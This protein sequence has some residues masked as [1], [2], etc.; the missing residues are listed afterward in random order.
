MLTGLPAWAPVRAAAV[1]ADR[2]AL[3]ETSRWVRFPLDSGLTRS[4][5]ERIAEPPGGRVWISAR[6]TLAWFDGFFWR[7]AETPPGEIGKVQAFASL[8]SRVVVVTD[9]GVFVESEAGPSLH[10]VRPESPSPARFTS[11]ARLSPSSVAVVGVEGSLWRLRGD[12]LEP[13]RPGELEG[14]L[15]LRAHE[16]STG[17]AWLETERGLYR[18]SGERWVPRLPAATRVSVPAICEDA[19]GNGLLSIDDPFTLRGVWRWSAGGPIERVEGL[20]RRLVTAVECASDNAIVAYGI[21]HAYRRL[22]GRWTRVDQEAPQLANV[23]ALRER[24]TGDL[25]VATDTGLHLFRRSARRWRVWQANGDPETSV[26]N[27][28]LHARDGTIWLG[29]GRGAMRFLPSGE[30]GLLAASDGLP[31]LAVTALGQDRRGRVW[32]AS[33]SF[34]GAYLFTGTRWQKVPTGTALDGRY[35]HKIRQDRA[36]RLWFLTLS[37]VP[38][39]PSPTGEPP[40]LFV[41]DSDRVEFWPESGA[42]PGSRVYAFAEGPDGSLWFGTSGGLS[43]WHEGG[44]RHWTTEEGLPD[45]RVFALAADRA[46]RVWLADGYT[47]VSRI[48][49]DRVHRFTT[50]DGLAS[51]AVWD[52]AVGEDGTVWAATRGGL[53]WYRDDVWMS[54]DAESGMP[55]TRLWPVLPLG[56]HVWLGSTGGLVA[57]DLRDLA[58]PTP[59]VEVTDALVWHGRALLRWRAAAWWSEIPPDRVKTRVRLDGGDW[60]PWSTT[61]EHRFDDLSP[62]AHVAAIQAASLA[63]P[64]GAVVAVD[65]RVPPPLWRDVRVLVPAGLLSALALGLTATLLVKQR[66][67]RALERAHQER[68]AE[69]Q[70]L[71]TIARLAGGVAHIFNNLL[72]VMMGH[73]DLLAVQ[74]DP[75]D[76]R[77]QSVGEIRAAADRAAHVVRQLLG[78]AQRHPIAPRTVDVNA[79]VVSTSELLKRLLGDSIDVRTDPS[80]EPAWADVDPTQIEQVLVQL[81]VNARDAM[82][83]GGRLTLAVSQVHI[84]TRAGGVVYRASPYILIRVTDTGAGIDPEVLPHVFEPFFSTKARGPGTGLGL[85]TCYG[86]VK[87]HGGWIDVESRPGQGTTFRIYVPKAA[88]PA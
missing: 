1:E 18:W 46:G 23:L 9:R 67:H 56:S 10:P 20:P 47:G 70:R 61:R 25:W 85:A 5:V 60:S 81:G 49:D 84:E 26:V 14:A 48:D 11:A 64:H 45:N 43:R 33:G 21:G 73:A 72:T 62:G 22:H 57:L 78:F 69:M 8:G 77:R 87:Q 31:A 71:E 36:G 24:P 2:P 88:P 29:T 50:R 32:A 7:P 76:P 6:D 3:T 42:L 65:F 63:G 55:N 51:D 13:W 12:A 59:R 54:F 40:A 66:R 4:R 38:G 80:P 15:A 41:L 27:E 17:A 39:Y 86:L 37:G 79:L 19:D 30:T 16:T 44:W 83:T 52:L 58:R 74:L 68:L 35:V 53:S 75:A 82:P 28:I 34:P